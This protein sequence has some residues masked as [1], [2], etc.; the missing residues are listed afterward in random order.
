MA[1]LL[2]KT[3]IY[4]KPGLHDENGEYVI[5]DFDVTIVGV[6]NRSVINGGILIENLNEIEKEDQIQP[7]TKVV[8]KHVTIM[9]S[10]GS[11]IFCNENVQ[12][13]FLNVHVIRSKFH[14]IVVSGCSNSFIKD[15][16]VE[17]CWNSGICAVN[18][19]FITIEGD[20]SIHNNC[21]KNGIRDFGIRSDHCN[22]NNSI[23]HFIKIK[24]E[25]ISKHNEGGGNVG[26]A[27]TMHCSQCPTGAYRIAPGKDSIKNALRSGI[28]VYFLEEGLHTISL[29]SNGWNVLELDFPVT[30]VGA[31]RNKSIVNGGL[32]IK[33]DTG[34]YQK[35]EIMSMT[36]VNSKESGICGINGMDFVIDDVSVEKCRYGIISYGTKGSIHNCTIK[37][38]KGS[39]IVACQN[40]VM[41]ISGRETSVRNNCSKWYSCDYGIRVY[42]SSSM[43]SL[44][45]PLKKELVSSDNGGGGNWGG[46]GKIVEVVEGGGGVVGGQGGGGSCGVQ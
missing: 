7:I 13:K 19:S 34:L 5:I 25:Q 36:F 42:D 9:N 45:F 16:H 18:G 28:E 43:V 10:N 41:E 33:G 38:N 27:G 3:V 15:C 31:D 23:I 37:N 30:L 6:A 1:K 8:I 14:G 22:R 2:N 11:G 39:G 32:V 4:L 12:F 24:P 29:N 26:G 35:V 21:T 17:Q 46:D 40:G 20:C 44:L